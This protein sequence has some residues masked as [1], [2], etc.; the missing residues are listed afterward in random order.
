VEA[1]T[2]D[3]AEEKSC[4]IEGVKANCGVGIKKSGVP[5]ELDLK[6]A[7]TKSRKPQYAKGEGGEQ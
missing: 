3:T 4:F 6:G 1:I 2:R 5:I 7:S